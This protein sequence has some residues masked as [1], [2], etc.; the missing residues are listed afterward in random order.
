M[1]LY[2]PFIFA[3]YST[4]I[5]D[6]IPVYFSPKKSPKLIFAMGRVG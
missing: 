1:P 6:H 2:S 5:F 3:I 4:S